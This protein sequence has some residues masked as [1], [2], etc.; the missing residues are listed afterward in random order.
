MNN[1]G[2]MEKLVPRTRRAFAMGFAISLGILAL[3]IIAGVCYVRSM[4]RS[5]IAQRD[6]DSL[7]A[8]TQMEQLDAQIGGKLDLLGNDE[9]I[10]FDAAILASRLKG[11]MGIRLFDPGGQFKDAF[12]GTIQPKA[13]AN[14]ALLAVRH[15]Q[16]HAQFRP[17]TPMSD[18]FIYLPEFA[19]GQIS[20]I[21]TLEVTVPLHKR[22]NYRLIGSVEFI[23]E[24]ASIQEEFTRLDRNLYGLAALTFV[25]AGTLLALMLWPAFRRQEKL[26]RELARHTERLERAN[27]E[28][29]LAARTSALGAV[30]A[31]LMHGLKNPLSS[32]SQIVTSRPDNGIMEEQ[33]WRDALSAAKRMQLLVEQT[34]DVVSDV[35]GGPSYLLSLKEMAEGIGMR[36]SSMA[37]AKKVELEISAESAETL[38]SHIANLVSLILVNLLENAIQAT[39][40][41]QKVQ[42][43]ILSTEEKFIF[44]VQDSGPGF[45]EHLR[46]NLFLPCRSTREGG[47]GI[48]L[49]ICKQIA[50][51][52]GAGLELVESAGKGCLFQLELPR[53]LLEV[54]APV[55]TIGACAQS[56]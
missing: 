22:D 53:L 3:T 16:T 40:S 28:L 23:V 36:V 48:G 9:Q 8:T 43:S 34:M 10:G 2:Y 33:D 5:Q 6:A 54:G 51:H 19:T 50:N 46:K 56:H 14:S 55:E 30:S 12:P 38:S 49:T 31:H 35:Q 29:A 7:Y 26:H 52:L 25:A 27:Q 13:L 15:F 47:S 20:R 11:V 18:V 17:E 4:V 24:G 39:R 44:Q 42:L 1:P 45:P 32:L 41:G 37:I 21:P